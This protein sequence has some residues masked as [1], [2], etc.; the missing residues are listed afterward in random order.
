MNV[1][2]SASSTSQQDI[3]ESSSTNSSP[4]TSTVNNSVHERYFEE[5]VP[6]QQISW[7]SLS[8]PHMKD[9][10]YFERKGSFVC[11]SAVGYLPQRSL[12]ALESSTIKEKVQR[13]RKTFNSGN[14]SSNS[15][16][17]SQSSQDLLSRRFELLLDSSSF[18]ESQNCING[19]PY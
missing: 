15:S 17:L 16:L 2:T 19:V 7:P 1:S 12:V 13:S 10:L 18:N 9:Y 3:F 4:S 14:T 11:A 8:V 5:Y 6:S